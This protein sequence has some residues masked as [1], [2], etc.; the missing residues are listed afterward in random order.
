MQVSRNL[1]LL[2]LLL[3]NRNDTYVMVIELHNNTI[4]A[5]FNHQY[6]QSFV[7]SENSRFLATMSGPIVNSCLSVDGETL[8]VTKVVCLWNIKE[9]TKVTQLKDAS[10]AIFT[11]DCKYMLCIQDDNTLVSVFL[12]EYTKRKKQLGHMDTLQF[13][14]AHQGVVLITSHN[15]SSTGSDSCSSEGESDAVMFDFIDNRII[16]RLTNLAPQGVASFSMDGRL[17][18]DY[19][20]QVYSLPTGESSFYI[21]TESSK[22]RPDAENFSFVHLTYDGRYAVWT[23]DLTIRVCRL[24]DRCMIGNMSTHEKPTMV[25]ILDYGYMLAVGREDGHILTIKLIDP[26]STPKWECVHRNTAWTAK[27]RTRA[28]LT[29]CQCTE[30]EINSFELNKRQL[31]EQ[32]PDSELFSASTHLSNRLMRKAKV[33]HVIIKMDTTVDDILT[34][35]DVE[36]VENGL[37]MSS[38]DHDKILRRRHSEGATRKQLRNTSDPK[39]R[40]QR[41]VRGRSLH[42]ILSPSKFIRSTSGLFNK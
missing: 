22:R 26:E 42:E 6:C 34:P 30:T 33:P 28:V 5:V 19:A 10:C 24:A 9:K 32:F 12:R 8:N 11:P 27:S 31:P 20:L 29:R 16:G 40:R 23:E 18:I 3:C 36:D 15:T 17:C 4:C 25:E 37:L 21:Q 7:L 39:C 41:S 38:S 1:S 14:P 13:L 2:C 35:E